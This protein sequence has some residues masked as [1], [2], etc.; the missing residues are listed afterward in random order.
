MQDA[1]DL[2]NGV[3]KKPTFSDLLKPALDKIRMR[4]IEVP[5]PKNPKKEK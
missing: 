3:E 1:D 4:L 5:L 2:A